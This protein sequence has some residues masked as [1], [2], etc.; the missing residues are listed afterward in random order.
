M[1]NRRKLLQTLSVSGIVGA[2]WQKPIIDSVLI[3]VH[4]S[5]SA[6]PDGQYSGSV[7][8]GNDVTPAT[9][10][11]EILNLIVPM[12]HAGGLNESAKID[13]CLSV[14]AGQVTGGIVAAPP[15][16]TRGIVN[17]PIPIPGSTLLQITDINGD[18]EFEDPTT[19]EIDGPGANGL[20]GRCIFTSASPGVYSFEFDIPLSNLPCPIPVVIPD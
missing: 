1:K 16:D 4:A 19:L 7:T 11:T 10:S 14:E 18:D 17:N 8:G 13:L 20:A 2:A 12:A 3:P 9:A 5:T 6:I 15:Y